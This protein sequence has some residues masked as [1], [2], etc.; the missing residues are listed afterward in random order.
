MP[1]SRVLALSETQPFSFRIRTQIADFIWYDYSGYAIRAPVWYIAKFFIETYD[2][3]QISATQNQN[4]AQASFLADILKKTWFQGP[5]LKEVTNIFNKKSKRLVYCLM[6]KKQFLA[7]FLS[8]HSRPP[9]IWPCV[10]SC[11]WWSGLV[12][13]LAISS[14]PKR[15]FWGVVIDYWKLCQDITESNEDTAIKITKITKLWGWWES[16]TR[17]IYYILQGCVYPPTSHE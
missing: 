17:W 8:V 9:K 12:N 7:L 1:F 2:Y 10:T 14:I 3:K 13:T 6:G 4:Q 11:L 16:K 5:S 15:N